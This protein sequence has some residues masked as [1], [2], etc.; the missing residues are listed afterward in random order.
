MY[1]YFHDEPATMAAPSGCRRQLNKND[2]QSYAIVGK[3]GHAKQERAEIWSGR[4]EEDRGG[5]EVSVA[6]EPSSEP[7]RS[8]RSE[9]HCLADLSRGS[10]P[11]APSG[12]CVAEVGRAAARSCGH[13]GVYGRRRRRHD[14]RSLL[15]WGPMAHVDVFFMLYIDVSIKLK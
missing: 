15:S 2:N 8:R 4:T 12:G 13:H 10:A 5:R 9:A 14:E 11:S 3:G 6:T 7:S 1:S